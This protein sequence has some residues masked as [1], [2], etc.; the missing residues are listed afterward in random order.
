MSEPVIAFVKVRKKQQQKGTLNLLLLSLV[1]VVIVNV[2]R[3][4]PSPSFSLSALTQPKIKKIKKR[5]KK[6]GPSSTMGCVRFLRTLL[7]HTIV[8]QFAKVHSAMSYMLC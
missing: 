8:A 6:K 3:L 4:G 1:N 2:V 5:G 7:L